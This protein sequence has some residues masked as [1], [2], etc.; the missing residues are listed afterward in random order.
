M[1]VI[2]EGVTILSSPDPTKVG[3][4][5][6]VVLETANTLIINSAGRKII[7]EKAGSDF[8]LVSGKVIKGEELAGRLEDRVGKR[9]S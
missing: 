4:K 8:L 1:N 2:G 6:W 9:S 7:V 3:R 5:G